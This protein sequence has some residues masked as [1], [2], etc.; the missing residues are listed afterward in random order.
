MCSWKRQITVINPYTPK[1]LIT[2]LAHCPG[3]TLNNCHAPD[4]HYHHFK[5]S[6]ALKLPGQIWTQQKKIKFHSKFLLLYSLPLSQ[7]KHKFKS[8]T[9]PDP[10]SSIKL[11][12]HTGSY[13]SCSDPD[14]FHRHGFALF[15]SNAHRFSPEDSA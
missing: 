9:A 4:L 5:A 7:Y 12:A 8:R 2:T 14:S 1:S 10:S 3:G 13:Y 6:N 15:H 11:V